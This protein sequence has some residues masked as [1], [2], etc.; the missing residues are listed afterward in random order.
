[1]SFG[2]GQ[3]RQDARKLA[4]LLLTNIYIVSVSMPIYYLCVSVG[5]KEIVGGSRK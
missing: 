2:D 3:V 5:E 4:D 1:M